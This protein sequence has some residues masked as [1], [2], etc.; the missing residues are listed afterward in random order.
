MGI[1]E[2]YFNAIGQSNKGIKTSETCQSEGY[3]KR[4]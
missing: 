2:K 4:I 3:C 1:P